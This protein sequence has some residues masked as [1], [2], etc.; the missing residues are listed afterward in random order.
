MNAKVNTFNNINKKNGPIFVN[1]ENQAKNMIQN[2]KNN[3]KK[4]MIK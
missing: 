2:N 1:D 3:E 4:N